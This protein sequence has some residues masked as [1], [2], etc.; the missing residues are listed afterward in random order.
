M[1]SRASGTIGSCTGK[2]SS[3]GDWLVAG[4]DCYFLLMGARTAN[5]RANKSRDTK[6]EILVRRALHAAGIRYLLHDKRLPGKPDIVLPSRNLIIE[7]R[8]CYWHAHGCR[9][10]ST[11]T[12]NTGY[13]G[14]KLARNVARDQQNEK[15]LQSM[16]WD[17]LVVWECE[18]REKGPEFV[19]E[20]VTSR[21]KI[22]QNRF[23]TKRR[24]TAFTHQAASPE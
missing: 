20:A 21:P 3:N 18:L 5:M 4:S 1:P 15:I 7:V 22:R 8:G 19:V 16:G 9:L 13:W 2:W 12:A 6:P 10:S 23:D 17:V 24:K 11:P 14:P